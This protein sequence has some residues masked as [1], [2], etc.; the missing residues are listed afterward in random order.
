MLQADVLPEMQFS[1]TRKRLVVSFDCV[2]PHTSIA[3]AA[4]AAAIRRLA[5]DD[6]SIPALEIGV[7]VL[8]TADGEELDAATMAADVAIPAGEPTTAT[9]EPDT[10]PGVGMAA[11]RSEPEIPRESHVPTEEP[12]FIDPDHHEP[13]P[14]NADEMDS[15]Q[16]L[17]E[18]N[19]LEFEGDASSETSVVVPAGE[20]TTASVEPETTPAVDIESSSEPEVP[21]ESSHVPTEEP[22]FFDPDRSEPVPGNADDPQLFA[23]KTVEFV[24][25]VTNDPELFVPAG[26]T[27]T[28]SSR[29]PQTSPGVDTECSSEPEVP[30]ESSSVPT[31]EPEFFD[32]DHSE[33]VPGN[34][35]E[36]ESDSQSQS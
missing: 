24:V 31:E 2:P 28:A 7:A 9:T 22:E 35:G 12:E 5:S 11:S 32:P 21:R 8:E 19:S 6:A 33:P 26:D 1:A 10:T 34:A 14:G 13:V 4:E 3:A 17:I 16:K 25:D 29:E 36:T 27:T 20:P 23:S 15:D 30:R 18:S